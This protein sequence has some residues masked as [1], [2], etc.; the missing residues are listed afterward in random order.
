MSHTTKIV[1]LAIVSVIAAG[2]IAVGAFFA[3]VVQ[4]H[5]DAYNTGYNKG[6]FDGYS[7]GGREGGD[8]GHPADP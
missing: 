7:D 4:A 8:H 1:L 6:Y 5:Q 2:L 3:G